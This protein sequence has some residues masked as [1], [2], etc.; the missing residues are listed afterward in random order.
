MSQD[1][2]LTVI[3]QDYTQ[4][5]STY[6]SDS[7][8]AGSLFDKAMTTADMTGTHLEELSKAQP[9]FNADGTLGSSR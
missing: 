1:F 8:L 4:S 5:T 3:R 6:F 2:V 7:K 9:I